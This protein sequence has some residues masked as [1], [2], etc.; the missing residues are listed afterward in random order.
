[1]NGVIR[2]YD[3]RGQRRKLIR[4]ARSFLDLNPINYSLS[5]LCRC[6]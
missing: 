4:A 1:M 5:K 6:R 3:I 2:D